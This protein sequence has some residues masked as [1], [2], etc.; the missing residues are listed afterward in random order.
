[1]VVFC[2]SLRL[3]G[4]NPTSNLDKGLSKLLH[5]K[6]DDELLNVNFSL[7]TLLLDQ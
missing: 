2:G 4:R 3:S 7:I 6:L 1:M 5:L